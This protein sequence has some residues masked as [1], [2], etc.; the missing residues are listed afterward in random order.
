MFQRSRTI[1]QSQHLISFY[2]V[3]FS[4]EISVPSFHLTI[5]YD[6]HQDFVSIILAAACSLAA[7]TPYNDTD[8]SLLFPRQQDYVR[9]PSLPFAS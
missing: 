9:N 5:Q 7:P 2:K 4:L 1:Y 8:I 3:S 6:F